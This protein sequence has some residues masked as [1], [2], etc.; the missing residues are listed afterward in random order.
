[1][2]ILTFLPIKEARRLLTRQLARARRSELAEDRGWMCMRDPEAGT[3]A[4][5]TLL[6]MGETRMLRFIEATA[7]KLAHIDR[8]VFV[9]S[10]D[11]V[12]AATRKGAVVEQ[13]PGML[14]LSAG[15]S[16]AQVSAYLEARM[17]QI[18]RKWEPDF[19]LVYGLATEDYTKK[20]LRLRVE[21]D[22]EI[23]L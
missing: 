8:L 15:Q 17:A 23:T 11:N 10:C 7:E 3:L 12:S 20:I 1:M 9:I 2:R 13:M 22:P 16:H 6:G 18:L 19:T 14:E 4:L 21:N 5:V